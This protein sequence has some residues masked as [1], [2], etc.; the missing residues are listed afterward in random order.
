M[1][2]HLLVPTD[3]S[4][5]SEA[6]ISAAVQFAKSVQARVTGFYAMPRFHMVAFAPE[7]VTDTRQEFA[8][9]CKAQADRFLA[10]IVQAAR[11][12]DV[13]CETAL[14]T[15]DQPY[16]AII[17]TAKEKGCDLIAMASHGRRGVEAFIL[18]SETQKVLTHSKI[19]VLVF[20]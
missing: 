17:A 5:R 6:A 4:E 8:K 1:F 20:R 10:V 16:E 11:A 18:G 3:G 13:P 9:D 2:K 12:A 14:Q 19:P 15:T 7:M